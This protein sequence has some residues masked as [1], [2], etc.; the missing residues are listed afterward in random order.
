MR[1]KKKFLYCE[2]ELMHIEVYML[3]LF[4]KPNKMKIWVFKKTKLTKNNSE[5]ATHFK[6]VAAAVCRMSGNRCKLDTVPE[7]PI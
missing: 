4:G 6:A 5:I 2:D 7:V 3:L 1:K